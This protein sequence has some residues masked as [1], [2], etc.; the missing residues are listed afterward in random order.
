MNI[1]VILLAGVLFCSSLNIMALLDCFLDSSYISSLA[2]YSDKELSRIKPELCRYLID[3]YKKNEL[4]AVYNNEIYLKMLND[5][6]IELKTRK[7]PNF[8]PLTIETDPRNDIVKLLLGRGIYEI[9]LDPR[10]NMGLSGF[11]AIGSI[12]FIFVRNFMNKTLELI[13]RDTDISPLAKGAYRAASD[14]IHSWAVLGQVAFLS[15]ATINGILALFAIG[16]SWFDFVKNKEE[17]IL[18]LEQVVKAIKET[19]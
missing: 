11:F 13:D 8:T 4:T 18:L 1:K 17:K 5:A 16:W 14:C 2:G 3:K 12:P 9:E 7:Y 10:Q 15:F 19:S 6:I